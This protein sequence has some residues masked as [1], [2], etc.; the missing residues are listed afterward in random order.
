MFRF[1]FFLFLYVYGYILKFLFW[2]DFLSFIGVL[3]DYFEEM[4][5]LFDLVYGYK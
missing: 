2:I 3:F 4:Y 1:D 5:F